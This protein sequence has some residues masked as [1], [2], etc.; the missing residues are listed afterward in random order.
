MEDFLVLGASGVEEDFLLRMTSSGMAEAFL[1]RV[2]RSVKVEDFL[3]GGVVS[4]GTVE[5][6]LF[7]CPLRTLYR[8]DRPHLL[9]D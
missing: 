6:F 7:F 5:T 4:S 8:E 1:F 3:V 2:R 9:I